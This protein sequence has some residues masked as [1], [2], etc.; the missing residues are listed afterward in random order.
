MG[1]ARE[2]MTGEIA[3]EKGITIEMADGTNMIIRGMKFLL[4]ISLSEP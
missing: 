4:P 1:G 2:G 3:G